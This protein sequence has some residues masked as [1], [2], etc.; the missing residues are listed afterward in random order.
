MKV[1]IKDIGYI[2]V[3]DSATDEEIQEAI[4]VYF[5]SVSASDRAADELAKT[6]KLLKQWV[7]DG[8]TKSDK[9]ETSISH[10]FDQFTVA[11]NKIK[12]PVITIEPPNVNVE[13]PTIEPPP[14]ITEFV[15]KEIK[16]NIPDDPNRK[17]IESIKVTGI[18]RRQYH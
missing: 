12:E 15:V 3:P 11:L 10:S 4:D 13:A 5:K 14:L 6:N 18:K 17:T 2:E 8:R 7:T 9:L 16:W 1:L